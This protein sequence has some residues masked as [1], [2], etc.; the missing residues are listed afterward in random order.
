MRKKRSYRHL[1]QQ[2]K[3]KPINNEISPRGYISSGTIFDLFIKNYG[4]NSQHFY[5]ILKIVVNSVVIR[6]ILIV[7]KRF[8]EKEYEE[9]NR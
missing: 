2:L 7:M 9:K 5:I 8:K 6:G 4:Q 1:L 3:K